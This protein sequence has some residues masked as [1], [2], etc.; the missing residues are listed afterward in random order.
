MELDLGTPPE[1]SRA[2]PTSIA[3]SAPGCALKRPTR[4]DE[5]V[6]RE[7]AKLIAAECGR[8][9]SDTGPEEW[10][11]DLVKVRHHWDDGYKFA[12]ALE[13]SCHVDPDADL[14]DILDG[15][16]SHLA[17]VHDRETRKWVGIVGFQP[18]HAVGDVV[19]CSQGTGPINDIRVETAQYVVDVKRSGNGGYIIN[20][21]D[22]EA[23]GEDAE[24][25]RN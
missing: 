9:D 20:A 22:I 24:D 3:A 16:Y 5:G 17:M 10:I 7:A 2:K 13:N 12:R 21:E 23:D 25:A 18:A 8:W 15:A 19:T 1:G 14:V 11:E 4:H 6:V